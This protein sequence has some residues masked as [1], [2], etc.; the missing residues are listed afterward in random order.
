[1]DKK[2]SITDEADECGD[3]GLDVRKKFLWERPKE[4]KRLPQNSNDNKRNGRFSKGGQR[5]SNPQEENKL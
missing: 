2:N 5:T 4:R 3:D 1:M